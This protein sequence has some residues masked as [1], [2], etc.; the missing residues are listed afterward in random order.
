M[1]KTVT[2]L[3]STYLKTPL[4]REMT[5][6]HTPYYITGVGRSK[7]VVKSR[8]LEEAESKQTRREQR[9]EEASKDC[10]MPP[11]PLSSLLVGLLVAGINRFA[12]GFPA[13]VIPVKTQARQQALFLS[14]DGTTSTTTGTAQDDTTTATTAATDAYNDT[15]HLRLPLLKPWSAELQQ[16]LE[17]ALEDC[18]ASTDFFIRADVAASSDAKEQQQQQ[19][20]EWKC[21]V[22]AFGNDCRVHFQL[23]PSPL[24]PKDPAEPSSSPP[25]PY[26]L[27]LS[28]YGSGSTM[29]TEAFAWVCKK[30]YECREPLELAGVDCFEPLRRVVVQLCNTLPADP[31]IRAATARWS[32]EQ[33]RQFE[34]LLPSEDDGGIR[35]LLEKLDKKGFVVID[36]TKD[37][38]DSTSTTTTT[39]TTTTAPCPLTTSVSNQNKLSDFLAETTGQGDDVRTDRVH[40]LSRPQAVNCGIAP[41]YDLLM[42]LANYLNHHQDQPIPR[43]ECLQPIAP[44]TTSRQLTV[45]RTIQFAEY[46]ANDFYTVR[47]NGQRK[48]AELVIQTKC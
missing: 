46:G 47:W 15:P 5:N 14:N 48:T 20:W 12:I 42:G 32:A 28:L 43:S 26:H 19:G 34:S 4:L 35:G 13:A 41:Q 21:R 3:T 10:R 37:E 17:A 45:P 36:G 2:G 44:A 38:S 8:G 24:P 9:E 7:Q 33:Q 40:F 6:I 18:A 1:Q 29:D 25:P 16:A 22:P 23:E 27:V 39:T 11:S 30:F 31:G